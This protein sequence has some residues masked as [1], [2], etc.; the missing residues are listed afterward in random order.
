MKKTWVLAV[1]AVFWLSGCVTNTFDPYAGQKDLKKAARIN[2]K[3]GAAYMQQGNYVRARSK[4]KQALE[5]NPDLAHAHATLARLYTKQSLEGRA[6]EQY[7][8]ALDLA[9]DDPG[10]HNQYGTFLCMHGQYK[11]AMEHFQRASSNPKYVTPQV[12]WT[13]AGVC[14]RR[15]Q[16]LDKAA[17]DLRKA[18]QLSP[19]YS[20]ALLQLADLSLHQEHYR[21]ARALMERYGKAAEPTATSLLLNVRIHHALGDTDQALDYAQKLENQF[22]ASPETGQLEHALGND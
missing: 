9:P 15:Q 7:R 19:R 10:L 3:L 4:L 18:L 11:R 5:Q 20:P 8:K 12:S 6:K 17:D 21:Q 14:E 1:V 2:T 13:N 22:P 16:H